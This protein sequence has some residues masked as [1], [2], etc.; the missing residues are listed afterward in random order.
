SMIAI[1]LDCVKEEMR[2]EYLQKV[3]RQNGASKADDNITQHLSPFLTA[4]VL[5]FVE[6][7]LKPPMGGPPSLPE[8]TDAVMA[9]LNLYRFVLI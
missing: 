6:F 5:D 1:L 4:K 2:K 9:A 7:V 8:F 3:S